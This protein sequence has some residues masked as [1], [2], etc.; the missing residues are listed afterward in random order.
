VLEAGRQYT[1]VVDRAWRDAAGRALKSELRKQFRAGPPVETAI[2]PAT[3]KITPPAAGS[4]GPVVVT[5]P[6]SLDH[7]LMER[8]M[9]IARAGGTPIVGRA[10]AA[11]EERRWEFHPERPWDAGKYQLVIDATLEDVAG[12]RIG[13]AFEVEDAAPLDK[14]AQAETVQLPFEISP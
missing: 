6:R 10:S 3:W 9:T 2:D 5:F 7:A 1:L 4:R 8:T 14:N 13:R 12:N 11:D